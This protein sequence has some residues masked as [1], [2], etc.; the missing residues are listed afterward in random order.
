MKLYKSASWLNFI[1]P[2][3]IKVKYIYRFGPREVFIKGQRTLTYSSCG[4]PEKVLQV[5]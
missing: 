1:A 5:S 3:L 4:F 2:L